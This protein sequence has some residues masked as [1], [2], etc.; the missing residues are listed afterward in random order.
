MKY[1]FWKREND[2]EVLVKHMPCA[3]LVQV[4]RGIEDGKVLGKVRVYSTD[5]SENYDTIHPLRDNWL[6]VLKGEAL[7]RGLDWAPLATVRVSVFRAVVEDA[8]ELRRTFTAKEMA[9]Q[10]E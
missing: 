9:K 3:V 5:P 4:I 2:S 7:K 8:W 1:D 10:L 6:T